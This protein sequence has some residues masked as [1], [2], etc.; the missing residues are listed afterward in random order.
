[1]A[2][3]FLL[4]QQLWNGWCAAKTPAFA[5]GAARARHRLYDH[6]EPRRA[7]I[8]YRRDSRV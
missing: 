7:S 1:M 8:L 2:R 3:A 5:R 4:V 6:D